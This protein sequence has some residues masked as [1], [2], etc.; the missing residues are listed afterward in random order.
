MR[1]WMEKGQEV[2]KRREKKD[3]EENEEEKK[4][5]RKGTGG[6]LLLIFRLHKMNEMQT[7]VTDVRSVGLSV[8]RLNSASPC[9]HD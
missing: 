4:G 2:T 6:G 3:T 8:T 9:K 7:I 5:S 1:P